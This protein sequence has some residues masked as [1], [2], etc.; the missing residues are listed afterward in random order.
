[1]RSGRLW[2]GSGD[3][4][5][6]LAAL[7]HR[8]SGGDELLARTA[9]LVS[10]ERA[11]GHVCIHLRDHA[12]VRERSG[13]AGE[14]RFRWP[15]L[16]VWRQR[17]QSSDLV[18]GEDTRALT[19]LVLDDAD[20]LFLSRYF[21]AER[22]LAAL[23]A[24]CAARARDLDG[25]LTDDLFEALF[26]PG[27][28]RVADQAA[29]ARAALRG[30]LTLVSGGPGTGK[31]TTV[32]RI[33]ALL[34]ASDPELRIALAAPTGKAA[35]R[36]G[37]SIAEVLGRLSSPG[38][39]P[40]GV[41][42]ELL[43]RVP[44]EARTLHRLLGYS[45]RRDRFR[46]RPDDPLPFDVVVVDE[47]S[48]VDLLMM[49]A[50][51]AALPQGAGLVLLGDRDQLASV[52]AGFVFGDL[53]A[54]A[55]LGSRDA[56]P[57]LAGSGVELRHSWRFEAQA[58]IGELARAVRDGRVGD[59]RSALSNGAWHQVGWYRTSGP[60]AAA[61]GLGSTIEDALGAHLD[62]YLAADDAATALERLAAFRILCATRVGPWGVDRINLLV[63]ALVARRG[64]PTSDRFYPRRPILVRQNDYQSQLFNGDLGICWRDAGGGVRA[65]F[66]GAGFPETDGLRSFPLATLPRHD[67]AWAMTVHKSQG[68]EFDNVLLVLPEDLAPADGDAARGLLSRELLYTGITRARRRVDLVAS[69]DVLAAALARSSRRRSGLVDALAKLEA[70][71]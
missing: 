61:G 27:D 69:D 18:A 48:M 13:E 19:P 60:S 55:G 46:H 40:R 70:P 22:R 67:T 23:L 62:A 10:R 45:P 24:A 42:D 15:D 43:A 36:L 7:V 31:T 32:S 38:L 34:L 5:V 4:D 9:A 51:V 59:A 50:L 57:A 35:A 29:S 65:V 14:E 39:S 6:A 3:V 41:D 33:L 66:P 58:G 52:E 20:R 64:H 68:S 2:A 28:E 37:E 8:L 47:A 53:C 21:R 44:R 11:L 54:A 16:G 56:S 26:P 30:G 12:G 71:L 49:D 17:L 63:E 1:M 25:A